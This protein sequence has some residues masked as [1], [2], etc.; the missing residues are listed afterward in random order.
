MPYIKTTGREI[1]KIS[2]YQ[3]NDMCTHLD[4]IK[5]QIKKFLE[6]TNQNKEGKS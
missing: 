4:K 5:D 3:K 6:V 1:S 2:V